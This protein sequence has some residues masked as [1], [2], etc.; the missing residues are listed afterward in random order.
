MSAEGDGMNQ[1]RK[2]IQII[3][4]GRPVT[5]TATELFVD[6]RAYPYREITDARIS[7]GGDLFTFQAG[8][9]IKQIHPAPEH[10]PVAEGV[11]RQIQAMLRPQ[12]DVES[13][14]TQ[15]SVPAREKAPAGL[16][17]HRGILIGECVLILL[18]ATVGVYLFFIA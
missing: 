18:L 16:F 8:G 15:E 17:S 1:D 5:F 10:R 12:A 3:S 14:P 11:F 7:G 2:A 6:G 4:E 9:E 13:A